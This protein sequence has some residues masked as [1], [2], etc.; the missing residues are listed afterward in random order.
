MLTS[1]HVI[2]FSSHSLISHNKWAQI[3]SLTSNLFS[4]WEQQTFPTGEKTEAPG[5]Q[6][7]CS[8]NWFTDEISGVLPEFIFNPES[9]PSS[10]L[11]EEGSACGSHFLLQNEEDQISELDVMRRGSHRGAHLSGSLL[12]RARVGHSQGIHGKKSASA[13]GCVKKWCLQK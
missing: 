7:S 5:F 13:S 10:Q 8:Q 9:F 2:V 1:F 3:C 12:P 4:Q 6:R 11:H